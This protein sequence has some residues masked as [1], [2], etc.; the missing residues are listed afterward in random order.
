MKKR[1]SNIELLKVFAMLLIALNHA[2]PVYGDHDSI[3]YL[4]LGIA[5]T[6]IEYLLIN[7][8]RCSGQIGNIIF[9]VCSSFFL[10]DSN[11]TKKEKLFEIMFDT[12]FLSIIFVVPFIIFNEGVSKIDIIKQ[13]MPFTFNNNWFICCYVLIYAIHPLLNLIVN[14]LSKIGFFRIIFFMFVLFS[15]AQFIFTQAFYFNDLIGFVYIYLMVAFV[16]KHKPK[17]C[18]NIKM[19]Y[20]VL[21]VSLSMYI[22]LLTLTNYAGLKIAFLSNKILHWNNNI[23]NPFFI[24]IGISLFNI[25]NCKYMYNKTINYISSLSLVFYLIHENYMFRRYVKPLFY[26]SVF[27]DGKYLFWIFVETLILFVFGIIF[28]IV[29][30]ELIKKKIKRIISYIYLFVKK[31]YTNCETK[32]FN[33]I[34]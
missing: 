21:F 16:K 5:S 4:D 31:I 29:Y 26:Q 27:S 12:L 8:L 14:N 30:N 25:F 11:K 34:D 13:F 33:F 23:A 9:I 2:M 20:F 32:I 3:A 6:N 10:V 1:N 18:E 24:L 28:A 19:N 7:F 17:Y 22:L 15:G